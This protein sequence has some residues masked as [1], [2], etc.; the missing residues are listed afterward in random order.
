MRLLLFLPAFACCLNHL[1]AQGPTPRFKNE[2]GIDIA[3]WIRNDQGIT[4]IWKHALDGPGKAPVYGQNALRLFAGYSQEEKSAFQYNLVRGDT[5]I[6]R[7]AIQPRQK[8]YFIQLGW[9]RQMQPLRHVRFLFGA[10]AGY[11]YARYTADHLER[12]TSRSSGASLGSQTDQVEIRTNAVRLSGFGGIEYWF[13]PRWSLGFEVSYDLGVDFDHSETFRSDALILTNDSRTTR[14]D[15]NLWRL[16]YV[17]Y[18]FGR[19][20]GAAA[21]TQR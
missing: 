10:D 2:I 6:E 4:L 11:R 20:T 18:H 12:Y 16:L 19:D 21:D 9:E 7:S 3:Q 15:A 5:A 8:N 17:A 1:A 13:S 14:A